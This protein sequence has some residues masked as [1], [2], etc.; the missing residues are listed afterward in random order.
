M[1]FVTGPIP[2]APDFH[3][4]EEGWNAIREPS[5]VWI[6]VLAIPVMALTGVALFAVIRYGT[7]TASKDVFARI[8]PMFLLMIPVHE[9]IH[10]LAN[11]RFGFTPRTAV[12][13]WPSH[14]L[15]YAHYDGELPRGRFLAILVAPTVVLTVFPLL[16]CIAFRFDAPGVAALAVA[17]GLGA[18]GDLL[19]VGFVLAQIPRGAV[20][21]NQGWR[22]YWKPVSVR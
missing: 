15:F 4:S 20:I 7:P 18:A 14:L 3:P 5:P 17:N 19:G 12:G 1:R 6:Q 22:S 11:P 21:R 13:V 2:E 8:G 16:V 9:L 10:A